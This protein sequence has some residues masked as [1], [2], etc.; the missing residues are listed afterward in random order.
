[1]WYRT[2]TITAPTDLPVTVDQVKA[3]CRVDGSLEDS[4]IGALIGQVV[5]YTET[6]CGLRIMPQTVQARCDSFR[7]FALLP[8]GPVPEAAELAVSYV[9]VEGQTQVLD[10]SV[11]GLL[12]E[13]LEASIELNPS[14]AWPA[15]SRGTRITVS[16]DVG[17]EEVPADL[18]LG[19]LLLISELYERR[20]N[21]AASSWT[22]FNNLLVNYRRRGL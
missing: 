16:C 7:D 10:E 19:M 6:Y 12:P 4:F 13:T 3:R 15:I 1:M 17:F 2:S 21:A 11:Y 14:Q 22:D 5:A 9:D 8:F 20:E 18:Q